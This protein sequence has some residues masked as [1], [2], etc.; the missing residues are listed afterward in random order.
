MVKTP[1]TNVLLTLGFAKQ[2]LRPCLKSGKTPSLG[3]FFRRS[4]LNFLAGRQPA[5]ENLP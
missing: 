2:N 5:R 1:L 4:A 3:I